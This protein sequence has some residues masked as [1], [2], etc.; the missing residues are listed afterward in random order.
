[1]LQVLTP[2]EIESLEMY[3]VQAFRL[4][5]QLVEKK[6]IDGWMERGDG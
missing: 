3:T 6:S 2:Y 4:M 5:A 1:M